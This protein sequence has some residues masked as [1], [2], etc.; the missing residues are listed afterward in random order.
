[1]NSSWLTL[2]AKLII[3][4]NPEQQLML[5]VTHGEF[6]MFQY[7]L[8]KKGIKNPFAWFKSA[9]KFK[10]SWYL[11]VVMSFELLVRIQLN[12][13]LLKRKFLFNYPK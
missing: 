10:S 6:Y 9:L 4:Y 12:I 11:A 8:K 13:V 3:T 1:M 2:K 5:L 7:A